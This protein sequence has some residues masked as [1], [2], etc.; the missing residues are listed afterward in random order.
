[1]IKV[2][3]VCYGN[4]CRSPMAEYIFKDIVKKE[5]LEQQF[6][7]DSA[8]TSNEEIG[9][10]AHYG[11][12]NKLREMNI[13]CE[14]H[15]AKRIIKQDYNKFDYIIGMEERNVEDI[16]RIVGKDSKNKVCKL[17]DFSDNPRNIA[18]P[19]YTGDFD[20]TYHDVVEGLQEFLKQIKGH[21]K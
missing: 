4:I 11:T 21:M 7:I 2:L 5:G 20:T 19:W 8:A 9:N 13:E 3:F 10:P 12:R 15:R 16:K 6:Y 18:D 14:N 17:L 1:M